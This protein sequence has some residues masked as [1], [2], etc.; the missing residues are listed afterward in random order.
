MWPNIAALLARAGHI[1]V[2][3]IAHI[4]GAAVAADEHAVLVT[5]VHREGESIQALLERL[6]KAI[7]RALYDGLCTNEIEGGRFE[8]AGSKG[9]KKRNPLRS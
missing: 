7:G 6:E 1:T 4:K 2:G 9:R 8:I 3:H 5:I